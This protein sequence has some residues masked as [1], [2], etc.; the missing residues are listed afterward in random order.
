MWGRFGGRDR[1]TVRKALEID[2]FEGKEGRA[3]L[4]H[5]R[6]GRVLVVGVGKAASFTLEKW[7]HAVARA[8]VRGREVK[9][10]EI[11]L[12]GGR[13]RV[14]EDLEAATR[15]FGEA[16]EMAV[17]R[18]SHYKKP[19]NGFEPDSVTFVPSAGIAGNPR[20]VLD[21]A[22]RGARAVNFARDL[23]NEPAC[24]MTPKALAEAARRIGSGVS[25]SV[26]DEAW[27]KRMKM[28]GILGVAQGSVNRPRFIELHYRPRRPSTSRP[29]VLVGKGVTFDSGGLS[30]K[31]S[32]SMETMKSDMSGAAA[33]LGTFR[34]LREIRPPVEVIGL[35]AAVE[36][37]PSGSAYRPGDVV[38]TM[39]GKTIEVNNTD[40]EGRVTLADALVF[41]TRRRPRLI[42]DLATLTGACVVALGERIA[43][44][45]GN[46]EKLVQALL[47]SG[48]RTGEKMWAMP[49]EED[50]KDLLKSEVADLKNAGER[51]AGAITA[52]LFLREFVGQTPWAHI[53]IAGPAFTERDLP[54]C[55]KGGT[56]FGVRTLVDFLLHQA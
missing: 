1:Q 23:V 33:V 36:N 55:P 12:A 13:H 41:A 42:V 38:R 11:V 39:A 25:V 2:R 5:V 47:A 48:E 37:M 22:V 56:G 40:A 16:A 28:G 27:I 20:Q 8:V 50:Y 17:Y 35:I 45:F 4:I 30:L 32:K 18:F 3:C 26:R 9:A 15:A 24:A 44:V 31:P 53:D 54:Y 51:Y 49:M 10:R 6:A 21:R 7:R 29:I 14:W 46:D 34:V 52:A 19:E 43:G